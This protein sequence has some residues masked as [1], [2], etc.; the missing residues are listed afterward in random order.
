MKRIFELVMPHWRRIVLAG[1]CSLVV[2]ALN[3]SFAWIVKPVV[4]NIFV[5]G[6]KT[7]LVIISL[8]VFAAFFL[9]GVFEYLQNYLMK[10]VGAKI[11]RDLRNQLYN[12]MV[13][14]PMSYYGSDS[15][16]A[17]LSRVMNDTYLLQ[18]LLA[19]RVKD[20]FVGTGTIIFLTGIAFYRRWD[21]TLIALTVL[22]VAFYAVGK[23]G[24]RLRRVSER[25]QK[26]I[27][28]MT[29]AISEGLSGIKVI[30]SFSMEEKETEKFR[31]KNQDYYREYMRGTRIME[32]TTLIMEFVAGVGVAFIIFYGG[33]LVVNKVIT[34]GDFFSFLAAILLIYTP[35]KR[36][37]QVNNGFQQAKAFI[38]RVDEILAKGKEA[39]G[40]IE[41]KEI[42]NDIVFD[43]VSF[44]YAGRDEDA[45]EDIN[46]RIKKGEV[47]AL[48]GRSGSGKTTFVDLIARF[49]SPTSGTILI[50]G[51]DINT[52]TLRSLRAQIGIVSQDVILFNDT[53]KANIAYGKPDATDEEII[54]AAKAAYAHEF[55]TALPQGYDTPIGEAGVMLS[56]GQRQR[57]SIARAILK[58]PS[59]LILDEATSSLDTQSELMVQKALDELIAGTQPASGNSAS[60]PTIFVIAH[61][62]STI[63]K[64][65]RIIVLDKG[66][67]VEVGSHDELLAAN[68]IYKKLYSLQ[69]DLNPADE[70]SRSGKDASAL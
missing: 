55:I 1:L 69:F 67:I 3:G 30:K 12:H 47:I 49:Y 13:Y 19:Y 17:M 59:I 20:L 2:S 60:Q 10:S 6:Q 29:E 45:L 8:A 24:K 11:V 36:L 62:L 27:A 58:K 31:D 9:R 61:R 65:D 25:A 56:G 64:A 51:T 15:T 14:L 16:G 50:D 42:K 38:G 18:E 54:N 33:S 44:K 52:L 43:N 5:Q 32:A 21:L 46:I 66:R 48:V 37:A 26:K 39:D 53:V 70:G 7:Y 23:L 68:G 40:H 35:A 34:A 41:L 22:P 4:D 57:L 63:K 28:A